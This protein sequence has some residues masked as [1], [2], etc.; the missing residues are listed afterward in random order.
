MSYFFDSDRQQAIASAARSPIVAR[1][2]DGFWSAAAHSIDSFAKTQFDF[3]AFNNR[4]NAWDNE[5][6]RFKDAGGSVQEMTPQQQKQM[7]SDPMKYGGDFG[8]F[9]YQVDRHNEA[10]PDQPFD[11]PS[12]EDMERRALAIGRS[13]QQAD[14][15]RSTAEGS[16]TG[17]LGSLAGD[18]LGQGLQPSNVVAFSLL[19]AGPGMGLLRAVGQDVLA[20]GVGQLGNEALTYG[21][22]RDLD[23]NYSA[24]DMARNVAE[25][26]L[27][28]GAFAAGQRAIGW[29]LRGS[30]AYWRKWRESGLPVPRDMQDAGN[31]VEHAA[32]I[33][34]AN[35]FPQQGLAG[36]N[37]H[38]SAM[39]DA[40]QRALQGKPVEVP[41]ATRVVAS[42][43][44]AATVER[45]LRAEFPEEMDRLDVLQRQH[46]MNAD[47]LDEMNR[48][49]GGEEHASVRRA[50]IGVEEATAKAERLEA[51]RDKTDSAKQRARLDEQAQAARAKVAEL[52]SQIDPAALERT[53][54]AERE[55]QAR[56]DAQARV[57]EQL[58]EQ[59]KRVDELKRQGLERYWAEASRATPEEPKPELPAEHRPEVDR[60]RRAIDDGK[61]PPGADLEGDLARA[62]EVVKAADERGQAVGAYLAG[63]DHVDNV[64]SRVRALIGLMHEESTLATRVSPEEF[65][66]RVR[67]LV[68]EMTGE[69]TAEPGAGPAREPAA[70]PEAGP[71]LT[72]EGEVKPTPELA[73][74]AISDDVRETAVM[75]AN[76]LLMDRPDL[77]VNI[78][79]PEGVTRRKLS[80]VLADFDDQAA[81]AAELKACALGREAAE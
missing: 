40:Y 55:R 57:E 69:R 31:V 16:F 77:E 29:G 58:A 66:R 3:A 4:A 63:L 52:E 80:D 21:F 53:Q 14:A 12:N 81:A 35:P 32:N 19:G 23:P 25:A 13:A 76:R 5:I 38:V 68:D 24:G 1:P 22:R 10:H 60:L 48:A 20:A 28:G 6:Q 67:S 73:K 30:V 27:Y 15:A 79:T 44:P 37:A 59:Q 43:L 72:K 47:R 75:D 71:P 11:L 64:N 65:G 62:H 2:V 74:E 8:W 18:M 42:E 70:A 61:L 51:A 36:E 26:G 49:L 56:A 17:A 46:D 39:Q 45:R 41:E 50:V 9:R 7:Q 78:V 34:A 33:E 54:F